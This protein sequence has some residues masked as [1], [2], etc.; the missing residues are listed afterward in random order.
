MGNRTSAPQNPIYYSN[1]Y[2]S[3]PFIRNL[4]MFDLFKESEPSDD[5][6]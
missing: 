4:D 6:N 5:S 1:I 2:M 3:E